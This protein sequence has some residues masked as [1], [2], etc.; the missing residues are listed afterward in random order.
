MSASAASHPDDELHPPTSDDPFW[1]ET[2]W[3]AFSVPERKLA[4]WFYPLMRTNQDVCSAAVFVWDDTGDTPP[5]L[6]RGQRGRL[7][8][9]ALVFVLSLFAMSCLLGRVF[10]SNLPDRW[11]GLLAWSIPVLLAV[12]RYTMF[13]RA[14]RKQGT[15]D[16][17]CPV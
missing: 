15:L 13:D 17:S 1:G 11:A 5:L 16:Q 7:G 9:A 14:A 8:E 12:L 10:E 4:A 2:S 6:H 3:W